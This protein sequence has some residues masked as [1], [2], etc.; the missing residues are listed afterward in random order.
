MSTI[1]YTPV[2]RSLFILT[3]FF[4]VSG[5][6]S[7]LLKEAPPAF[8][9]QISMDDPQG[10][11]ERIK[12]VNYPSWKSSQTQNAIII[13]SSCDEAQSPLTQAHQVITESIED[14][15]V[16]PLSIDHLKISKFIAKRIQGSIDG[17]P[18]QVL[19]TAFQYKN[20][21]YVSALSG[22]PNSMTKDVEAW[23]IFLNSIEF[24][25]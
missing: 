2:R 17:S 25:K 4:I 10:S 5:C 7:S 24:K 1:L 19:T 3:L 15:K 14:V 21:T 18:V 20:C 16:E 23:K 12:S 11:F 9:N 8:S 13:I 22:K 6:I